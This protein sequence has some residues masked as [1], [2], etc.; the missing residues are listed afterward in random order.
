MKS[1]R[2]ARPNPKLQARG[3]GVVPFYN[4]TAGRHGMHRRHFCSFSNQ[5]KIGSCCD[6]THFCYTPLF[7]DSFFARL[8]RAVTAHP[9]YR[10]RAE[11]PPVSA[12]TPLGLRRYTPPWPDGDG[13]DGGD[14]DGARR[15]RSG[16]RGSSRR[17]RGRRGRGWGKA[18]RAKRGA[19]G[20]PSVEAE[21]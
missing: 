16:K 10:G 19:G 21:A 11:P 8:R 5:R 7:W 18:R 2:T 1:I 4:L 14:G 13:G 17:G 9:N 20:M 15:R 3:V 6:C 12:A